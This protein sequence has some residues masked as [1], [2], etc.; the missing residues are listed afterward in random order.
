MRIFIYQFSP[1]ERWLTAGEVASECGDIVAEMF[2][3][4]EADALELIESTM[5][6]ERTPCAP[7]Y[8]A[9]EK[10]A[11]LMPMALLWSTCGTNGMCAGNAPREALIQGISEILERY[12]IRLLYEENTPPPVVPPSA[13]QGTEILARL[14]AMRQAGLGY[15]IRDCSMGRGL[16]VM[17]LRLIRQ[18]GTQAFHLGADPSPITA[19]ERCL[20][21]LYQGSPED[22]DRRYHKS[23]IGKAPARTP[24]TRSAPRIPPLHGIRIQRLWQWPDCVF[25]PGAPFPGFT[26][27]VSRSDE[28]DLDYL[29]RLVCDLGRR[30]F[31][32]DNSYLG[33]P[34]YT[35]YIPGM[36]EI[37]FLFDAPHFRD[38]RAWTRF[39]REHET[40]LNLP[41]ADEAALKRLA[42]ALKDAE[43]SCLTDEFQPGKWF[44]SSDAP[45]TL[46]RDR[47][48][49][50]ALL[51]GC[52]GL[53]ADAAARMDE[54]LSSDA[55]PDAPRRLLTALRDGWRLRAEGEPPETVQKKLTE[56]FGAAL[57]ER[58]VMWRFR[59]DE[60]PTCFDC[61]GCGANKLCRFEALC[62]R[63]QRVQARIAS[64]VID[65]TA[66]AAIFD[67]RP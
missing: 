27:P 1:D 36:S 56:T 14:E 17:G 38:L 34:A 20:T 32:R 60:W 49:F 63:Q 29:L 54:F 52:A 39:A 37:D 67:K 2:G 33:F 35:V 31:I 47:N 57:A 7:F 44:L 11:R 30:L 53:F 58:A 8:A 40:L 26:H 51:Y 12:A 64:H 9:R 25:E 18:D 21:K 15:E 23:G 5:E 59:A 66:L 42:L 22:N 28:D 48:V 10:K 55:L 45:P 46:A 62:R 61:A 4:P 3:I 19:L 24:P 16:P 13:F 50:A 65:Q 6:G 43:E 41:G